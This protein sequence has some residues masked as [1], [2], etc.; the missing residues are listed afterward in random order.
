[1]RRLENNHL[2]PLKGNLGDGL[3]FARFSDRQLVVQPLLMAHGNYDLRWVFARSRIEF[4]TIAAFIVQLINL[5]VRGVVNRMQ[6]IMSLTV[7]EL[8]R[9]LR[10]ELWTI[11]FFK[12]VKKS[13]NIYKTDTNQLDWFELNWVWHTSIGHDR[14][15]HSVVRHCSAM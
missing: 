13:F 15:R 10:H 9:H 2:F 7:V 3:L 4:K 6:F 5:S 1:M 8:S 11:S 14:G 12:C